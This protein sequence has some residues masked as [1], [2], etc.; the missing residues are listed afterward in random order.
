MSYDER[1]EKNAWRLNKEI[2]VGDLLMILTVGVPL[3]IAAVH[4]S[5]KVDDH[6]RRIAASEAI[7]TQ[8]TARIA[9]DN[10]R[11]AVIEDKF[12]SGPHTRP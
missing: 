7:I 8:H 6:D 2:T 9:E 3:L 4:F 1:K 12:E 5:D 10:T 11:L